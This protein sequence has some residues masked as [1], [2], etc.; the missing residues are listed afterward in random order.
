MSTIGGGII[1][2]EGTAP[3]D[4]AEWLKPTPPDVQARA[5]AGG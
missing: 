4:I 1:T 2:I 5:G 3:A